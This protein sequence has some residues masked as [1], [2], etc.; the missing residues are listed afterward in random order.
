MISIT[1][2]ISI[3]IA[4]ALMGLLYILLNFDWNY[5][6]YVGIYT[7]VYMMWTMISL[8]IEQA[9][10]ESMYG[11]GYYL[12][13]F[14]LGFILYFVINLIAYALIG[15]GVI[16]VIRPL[17]EDNVKLFAAI[18]VIAAFFG[19]VVISNITSGLL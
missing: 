8:V 18:G 1:N 5:W 10:V 3:I 17:R 15:A 14:G 11:P 16:Y 6:I 4:S 12:F 13:E 9:L 2:G 7:G 19:S